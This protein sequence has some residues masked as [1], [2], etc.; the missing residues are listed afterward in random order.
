MLSASIFE[1]PP[2]ALIAVKASNNIQL[3]IVFTFFAAA[4]QS[5]DSSTRFTAKPPCA[6][7]SF[8]LL[9]KWAS[10]KPETARK[11]KLK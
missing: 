3:L 2:E 4:I 1:S 11:F 10:I 6:Q 9:P 8:L 5:L 7:S